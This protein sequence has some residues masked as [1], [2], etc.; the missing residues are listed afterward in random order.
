MAAR[1]DNDGSLDNA[2]PV[3][4]LRDGKRGIAICRAGAWLHLLWLTDR[5]GEELVPAY[6]ES[7]DWWR[8]NPPVSLENGDAV[9]PVLPGQSLTIGKD[10]SSSVDI[11]WTGEEF[12]S[13]WQGD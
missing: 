4:R 1:F 2:A 10:D 12:S 3:T 13:E 8:V 6:F 11:I 9:P 7:I 5:I